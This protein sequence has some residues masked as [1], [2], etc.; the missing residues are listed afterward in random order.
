M[1]KSGFSVFIINI[2]VL[3]LLAYFVGLTDSAFQKKYSSLNGISYI[4]SS[5]KYFIFW[6]LPYWWIIIIV[7]S[8]ILTLLYWLLK[9]IF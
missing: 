8:L 5:I 3:S 2:V 7:G 1:R 4:I 9:K 6:V